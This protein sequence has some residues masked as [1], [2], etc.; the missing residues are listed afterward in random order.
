MFIYAQRKQ[1][2]SNYSSSWLNPI[3][4]EIFIFLLSHTLKFW[5]YS[6]KIW[7]FKSFLKIGCAV[8]RHRNTPCIANVFLNIAKYVASSS[9]FI[10]LSSSFVNDCF[11]SFCSFFLMY[12]NQVLMV[13]A[14]WCN[15]NLYYQWRIMKPHC[16]TENSLWQFGNDLSVTCRE[17][18]LWRF[19]FI[20]LSLGS[21]QGCCPGLPAPRLLQG[22]CS[23]LLSVF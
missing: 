8:T 3:F 7:R 11:L 9:G 1:S 18:V 10:F 16:S 5:L 15:C 13:L 12:Q 6:K 21:C 2:W 14:G 22:D 17:T 4:E 23:V 19:T 20:V